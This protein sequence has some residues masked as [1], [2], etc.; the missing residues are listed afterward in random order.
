MELKSALEEKLRQ[1]KREN[2]ALF[3]FF[4][5]VALVMATT[6]AIGLYDGFTS[7]DVDTTGWTV[8]YLQVALV[9]VAGPGGWLLVRAFFLRERVDN[10]VIEALNEAIRRRTEDTDMTER[11]TALTTHLDESQRII[12]ELS[13]ELSHRQEVLSKNKAEAEHW[14]ERA[15]LSRGHAEPIEKILAES[16]GITKDN[17]ALILRSNSRKSFLWTGVVSA[18]LVGYVTNAVFDLTKPFVLGP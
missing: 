8:P 9:I 1:D 14:E 12:A 11:L 2:N 5:P 3:F 13:E 6:F 4:V 18:F 7:P 17:L 10:Q 15:V 16:V